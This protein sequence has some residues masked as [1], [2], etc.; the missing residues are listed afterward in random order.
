M[1]FGILS[2]L[3]PILTIALAFIT[4][5]VY[6]ALF[7]GVVSAYLIIDVNPIAAIS[8]TLNG[9]ISTF[10][11]SSNTIVM[12]TILVL[13]ALTYLFDKTGAI[14]GFVNLVLKKKGLVKSKKGAQIFTFIVGCIVYTSG[15]LSTLI[16]GSVSRPINDSLKVPH[17]KA[18]Y[19]VHTTSMPICLLIPLSGWAGVMLGCLT[20]AG[21]DESEAT[22]LLI[23]SIP[24]NVYAILV[25]LMVPFFALTGLDFGPMK[26]AE[27]R[28]EQ[29]GY[30]DNPSHPWAQQ[31][32][33]EGK[34]S[35]DFEHADNPSAALLLVPIFTLIAVIITVL[36]V[37]GNGSIMSGSGM[38]AVLWAPAVSIFV[39]GIM[40]VATKRM[41]VTE[42]IDE[43]FK[44][45]S[46]M[47][48]IAA[49]LMMTYAL[50]TCISTLGTGSYLA[51]LFNAV[52]SPSLI[53][54][55]MFILCCIL[56]YAT[57]TSTGTM[58][59]MML[60]AVPMA[61][62]MG[63]N[64]ALA[65]GS[66]WAGALFGDHASIISDTTIMSCASTGC[67]PVD[68]VKSQLPYCLIAAAIT[69]VLY[70]I[71]GLAL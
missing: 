6:I 28:A 15:T 49:M 47:V 38:Q 12:G 2:I 32:N 68:H 59:I 66:V 23:Q 33:E 29:T 17:E 54:V 64:L 45:A 5:S 22:S 21:I 25:V 39:L 27:Q 70:L 18:A 30:L 57:G 9:F 62:E 60:I 40:V 10:S 69:L 44:G 14:E 34:N 48:S 52:L 41:K 11:S 67:D 16:T 13:G 63:G 4:R 46:G 36:L 26:K 31:A 3:P 61:Q 71:F 58:T 37:T 1:E 43:M 51:S 8:D 42:Y 50:G 65:V 55:V 35:S 19:I 53:P 20:S 7:L 56:S 24:F